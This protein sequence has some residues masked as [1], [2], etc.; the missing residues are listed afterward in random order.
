MGS[1]LHLIY[2]S[3]RS[4][5]ISRWGDPTGLS[6]NHKV[7]S[8]MCSVPPPAPRPPARF[9]ISWCYKYLA[10]LKLKLP[11]KLNLG[12]HLQFWGLL[13]V[14]AGAQPKITLAH[15]T[16]MW[17]DN[18]VLLPMSASPL[19]WVKGRSPFGWGGCVV[20]HTHDVVA[21]DPPPRSF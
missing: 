12:L 1:H 21:E 2:F 19:L 16:L 6:P 8:N 11:H 7:V 14:P 5:L 17:Q 10:V 9:T 3:G 15:L 18:S 4:Q 20:F 13:R